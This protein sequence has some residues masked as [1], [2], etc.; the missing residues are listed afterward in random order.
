MTAVDAAPGEEQPV[1]RSR[2]D[3]FFFA[4]QSTAPM[5]LVRIGWG[6]LAALWGLTMLPDVDPFFTKGALM[7]ERSTAEG[8]WD[9]LARMPDGAGMVVCVVLIVAGLATM[10]GFRTRLSALVA[11]LSLILLQRANSAIFNSGDLLLRQVGIAVV[12]APSGLLWSL[13]AARDRRKGRTPDLLRAPYAMR[14]LQL[15]LALGYFLSAWTKARGDTW[16]NGT[17]IAFSLRIEDLQR[18][19]APE[20][21]F[22]QAVLLNLFTWSALAFEAGFIIMVWPRRLRLWVLAAGVL[23]HLGIDVFLDIGFFSMAIYLAY[24]AFLPTEIAD[25]IVGRFDERALAPA[26]SEPARPVA[27]WS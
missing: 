24:L 17:A 25:R 18:Y 5:A 21:V 7:Y 10:L 11:V 26:P 15:E 1:P 19:V 23:F 13:D 20:W 4:P 2:W 27:E 14:L 16:H 12:L 3:A 6:A 8:S 22:D 9:L